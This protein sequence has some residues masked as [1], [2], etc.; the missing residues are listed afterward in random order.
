MSSSETVIELENLSKAFHKGVLVLDALSLKV[1]QG[2][3]VA[4]V[5]AN[6]AGK[7]TLIKILLG[8]VK[9]T[10]GRARL[11]GEEPG[12]PK[13]L[14]RIGYLPEVPGFWGELSA[15]EL[16]RELGSLR[17]FSASQI[18]KRRTRLLDILGLKLRGSRRMA[19]YSKGMLQRTGVA[20][21]MLHDPDF[22]ILDEPM[23]GLD[24]RAQEKLRALLLKLKASGKTLLISSHSLEDIRTLCDRVV[25]LEKSKLVL[26]GP[27]AIVLDQLVEKYRSSDPW[28]EDPLGE[29]PQDWSLDG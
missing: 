24:P 16:L 5:G 15:E 3:S 27:T 28:D 2:E 1:T 13:I 10:G 8:F 18:K 29:I 19:G 11:F 23:S 26:D 12:D 14:Q 22:L 6:G 17:D 7:S 25:V 9:A 20:A 4:L 21:A